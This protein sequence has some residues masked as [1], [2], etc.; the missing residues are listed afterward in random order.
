MIK[1]YL[2]FIWQY[3]SK[4]LKYFWDPVFYSMSE[5]LFIYKLL[6]QYYKSKYSACYFFYSTG[7]FTKWQFKPCIN[8][9]TRSQVIVRCNLLRVEC[10]TIFSAQITKYCEVGIV[11]QVLTF[12]V[13]FDPGMMSS[14]IHL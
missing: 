13:N 3:V 6:W 10:V 2:K 1:R 9:V 7:L 12:S 8:G 4:F 11:Y 14:C 5:L